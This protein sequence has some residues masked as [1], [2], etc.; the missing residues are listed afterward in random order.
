[1][2]TPS[3]ASVEHAVSSPKTKLVSA[4]ADWGKRAG[5]THAFTLTPDVRPS[6]S[7][8]PEKM[9]RPHMRKLW[10]HVTHDVRGVP[11]G[12]LRLP[13]V[14]EKTVW[15]AGFVELY[16]KHGLLY[17]HF[18]GVVSLEPGELPLF[19]NVLAT[20][21]GRGSSTPA[22]SPVFRR[23]GSCPD[24]DTKSLRDAKGWAGYSSKKGTPSTLT[25]F[26]HAELLSVD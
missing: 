11:W 19:A 9:L 18:H 10:K 24:F 25:I 20:R 3:R 21:W 17:P 14:L 12:A 15:M 7:Y 23:H 22:L 26:T 5:A 1:M 6:F 4:F 2:G 16:D 13:G 8:D